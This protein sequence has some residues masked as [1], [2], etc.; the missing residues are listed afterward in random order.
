[1]IVNLVGKCVNFFVLLS[2]NTVSYLCNLPCH[3]Q[4]SLDF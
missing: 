3:P 2:L 1:V 4:D